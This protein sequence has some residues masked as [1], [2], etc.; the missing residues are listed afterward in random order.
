MIRQM[1]YLKK[2]LKIDMVK[3]KVIHVRY[4]VATNMIKEKTKHGVKIKIIL[5]K[6]I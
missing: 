1:S 3:K 5:I 2:S 6:F 4:G